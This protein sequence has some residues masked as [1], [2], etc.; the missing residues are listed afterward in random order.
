M[1]DK[2]QALAP[3]HQTLTSGGVTMRV[4]FEGVTVDLQTAS[5][6]RRLAESAQAHLR[7]DIESGRDSTGAALHSLSERTLTRRRQRANQVKPSSS[8]DERLKGRQVRSFTAPMNET[9]YFIESLRVSTSG[10]SRASIT[11]DGGPEIDNGRGARRFAI[12]DDYPDLV[13]IPKSAERDLERIQERHIQSVIDDP[14]VGSFMRRI[15]G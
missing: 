3:I 14:S 2:I 15:G 8:L 13:G 11:S 6:V 9:G 10:T 7:Q 12:R 5:L 1:D 4:S